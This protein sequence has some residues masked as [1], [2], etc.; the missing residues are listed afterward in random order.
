[1]PTTAFVKRLESVTSLSEA[2]KLAIKQLPVQELAIKADQDLVRQGDR[3]TRTCFLVEGVACTYKI[4]SDSKRQ[5]VNFHF[6]GDAPDLQSMHLAFLDI[7]IATLT[8]AGSGFIQHIHLRE[9]CAQMPG[10][11]D[12][13]MAT[14]SYRRGYLS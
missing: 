10:V 1:M 14:Y 7:S 11:A 4:A 12:R 13:S 5:I 2:E 9:L 6:L 8:L 3:P